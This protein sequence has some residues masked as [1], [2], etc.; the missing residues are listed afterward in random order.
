VT[1]PKIGRPSFPLAQASAEQRPGHKSNMSNSSASG[2][3]HL[4]VS[5]RS[6]DYAN[7]PKLSKDDNPAW[8]GFKVHDGL[9]VTVE[10]IPSN[11]RS[12]VFSKSDRCG[13]EASIF[14]S[15]KQYSVILLARESATW[16]ASK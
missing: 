9:I 7:E 3:K 14:G 13:F 8:P 2:M 11:R 1:T 15:Q 6:P 16:G 5:S 10:G 4:D 12:Q